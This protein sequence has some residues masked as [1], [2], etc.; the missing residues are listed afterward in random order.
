[1]STEPAATTR[2]QL[3]DA[4]LFDVV[5]PIVIH[6]SRSSITGAPL[7]SYRDAERDLNFS[8]TEITRT[9]SPLGEFVTVTLDNVVDAFVLTFTL[10]VPNIRLLRGDQVDFDTLG[11]ETTDR[12]GA[13][14][15][16][17]GPSGVL[18]TYRIH[19]LRGVARLVEF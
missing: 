14:V 7:F 16:A 19:E 1:M 8:D 5:G 10:L 9:D 12:S 3:A 18:Q 13:F 4:N 11:I 6:Y 2:N 17:P 15:P